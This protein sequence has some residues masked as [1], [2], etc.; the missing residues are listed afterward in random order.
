M[1]NVVFSP[2]KVIQILCGIMQALYVDLLTSAELLV[3]NG[4][5]FFQ[6]QGCVC[7]GNARNEIVW[8]L[9]K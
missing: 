2:V 6:N 3:K 9:K 5:N 8:E 1:R 4:N 7:K